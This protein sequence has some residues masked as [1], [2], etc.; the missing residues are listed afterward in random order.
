MPRENSCNRVFE[1]R[2]HQTKIGLTA[3]EVLQ[4]KYA[5]NRFASA[6]VDTGYGF[7]AGRMP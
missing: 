7:L 5:I 3:T 1:P 6:A 2:S 4:I